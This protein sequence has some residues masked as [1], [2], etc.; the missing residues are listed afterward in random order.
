MNISVFDPVDDESA[1]SVFSSQQP[2]DPI[3]PAHPF[4]TLTIAHLC[5]LTFK[6]SLDP[7]LERFWQTTEVLKTLT[8]MA[9]STT[10]LVARGVGWSTQWM[11][12]CGIAGA[13]D[14][15]TAWWCVGGLVSKLQH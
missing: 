11:E 2:S 1:K 10:L 12:Q 5:K 8:A 3:L 4:H 15:V 13:S 7:Y 6:H 9:T 14:E